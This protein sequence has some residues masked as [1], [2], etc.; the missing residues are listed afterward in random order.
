MLRVPQTLSFCFAA[1]DEALL[2]VRKTSDG[3]ATPLPS[4]NHG[5]PSRVI[6]RS[7][8]LSPRHR[9]PQRSVT[10]RLDSAAGRSLRASPGSHPARADRRRAGQRESPPGRGQSTDRPHLSSP[11]HS[12]E[13]IRRAFTPGRITG[14]SNESTS[15]DR[16]PVCATGR[17]GSNPRRCPHSSGSPAWS[18]SAR[19][20]WNRV[21]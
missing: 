12:D 9:A 1:A 18:D 2:C 8:P 4:P 19:Y 21:R 14:E 5:A 13:P 7:P 15:L 10:R 11:F 17:P 6:R 16:T 20:G 3:I